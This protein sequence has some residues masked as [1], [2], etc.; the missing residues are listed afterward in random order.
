MITGATGLAGRNITTILSK[1]GDDIVGGDIQVNRVSRDDPLREHIDL[2]Q[3]DVRDESQI[4]ELLKQTQPDIIYH[5]AAVVPISI[6]MATPVVPLETNIIG[7]VNLFQAV[8]K[9]ALDPCIVMGGSSEEYGVIHPKEIPVDEDQPLRPSNPYA[10]SKVAQS[11]LGLQYHRSYGLRVV[12]GRAFNLTGPGQ[13]PAYACSAFAK[14]IAEIEAGTSEPVVRVGNL[15][16]KR[17]YN[18]IRDVA[19]A[20][21]LLGQSAQSGEIYN[22]CTGH[23]YSMQEILDKLT[24]LAG[25]E[26]RVEVDPDRVR[27]AENPLIIGDNSKLVSATGYKPTYTIDQ[28]LQ[29]V[30]EYWRGVLKQ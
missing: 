1:R 7:T 18:D 28:T 8:R 27:A 10:V 30:L 11:L 25:V 9:A 16:P 20:Y 24:K 3:L 13:I 23:P 2:R 17:D 19:R 4:V 12:I 29:D 26:I 6:A 21:V 15:L 14:Q 5:M 22:I